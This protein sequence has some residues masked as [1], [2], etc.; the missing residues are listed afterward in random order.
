MSHLRRRL[1]NS[2]KQSDLHMCLHARD[3]WKKK[4]DVYFTRNEKLVRTV[5]GNMD[6]LC[7]HRSA[8]NGHLLTRTTTYL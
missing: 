6:G 1:S 2:G 3:M 5:E 8:T 7:Q 4:S